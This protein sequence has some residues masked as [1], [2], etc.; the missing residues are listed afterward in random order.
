[1]AVADE[2]RPLQDQ[3]HGFDDPAG[4]R[5]EIVGAAELTAQ[6]VDGGVEATVRAPGSREFG[7]ERLDRL[8]LALASTPQPMAVA[9]PASSPSAVS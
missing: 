7:E 1:V 4:P 2:E 9:E 8:G 3:R 5:L 6:V